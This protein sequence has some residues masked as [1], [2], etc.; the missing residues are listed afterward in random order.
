MMS[1]SEILARVTIHDVLASAG[2]APHGNRMACPIHEGKNRSSF[3]FTDSTFCCHSCGASGG[4]LALVEHLYSCDRRDA[5]KRLHQLAGIPRNDTKV[6]EENT[7]IV[8]RWRRIASLP[9]LRSYPAEYYEVENRLEW[10]ELHRHALD[11]ALQIIRRNVK[12][13]RV[14]LADFYAKEQAYLHELEALDTEIPYVKCKLNKI[15]KG[16]LPNGK[17]SQN[18]N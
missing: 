8:W 9:R 17:R 2:H 1:F 6:L 10:L 4:L 7:G 13:G 18:S 16:A 12:R 5:L 11:V 3:S 15:K 14:P